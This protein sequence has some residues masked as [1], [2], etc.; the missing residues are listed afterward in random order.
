MQHIWKLLSEFTTLFCDL[1]D[2]FLTKRIEP[3]GW[4]QWE[5]ADLINQEVSGEKAE[6]F[7]SVTQLLFKQAGLEYE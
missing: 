6:P 7:A 4:V 3:G 1:R 5:D 2:I